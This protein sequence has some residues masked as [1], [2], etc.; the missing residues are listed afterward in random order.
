MSNPDSCTFRNDC[1]KDERIVDT[2]LASVNV[3]LLLACL[4]NIFFAEQR[5]VSGFK[6][7]KLIVFNLILAVN[8]AS[9]TSMPLFDTA[10][11]RLLFETG[12]VGCILKLAFAGSCEDNQPTDFPTDWIYVFAIDGHVIVFNILILLIS[13][14]WYHLKSCVD[15]LV[16]SHSYYWQS[17]TLGNVEKL[18]EIRLFS[19]HSS[20]SLLW[21]LD[22]CFF[23]CS[24][25]PIKDDSQVPIRSQN[26]QLG[27]LPFPTR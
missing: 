13:R 2:F 10:V 11:V 12:S 19:M 9:K 22:S 18:R 25:Y 14:E 4:G 16:G 26:G 1:A 21:H 15:I 3:L 17:R 23:F 8:I 27:S 20:F 5:R 6:P 7:G 24:E